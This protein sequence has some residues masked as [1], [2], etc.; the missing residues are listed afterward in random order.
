MKARLEVTVAELDCADEAQQ[1][2]GALS[3][4]VHLGFGLAAIKFKNSKLTREDVSGM[5]TR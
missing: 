5:K 3:R 1:I 4:L 2:Q